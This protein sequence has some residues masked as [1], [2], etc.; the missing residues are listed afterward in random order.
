MLS[1]LVCVSELVIKSVTFIDFLDCQFLFPQSML[2]VNNIVNCFFGHSF[3]SE[4]SLCL[5]MKLE[6]FL[7]GC[8]D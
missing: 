3:G 2:I 5:G 4:K 8:F 6:F 7:S 1:E